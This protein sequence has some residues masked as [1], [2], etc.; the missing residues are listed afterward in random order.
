MTKTVLAT[1]GLFVIVR[2]SYELYC[3][4]EDMRSENEFYR[5]QAASRT[6]S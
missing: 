5:K 4:Y 3:R 1:I 2:K 6:P